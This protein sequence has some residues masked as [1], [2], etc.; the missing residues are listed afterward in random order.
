MQLRQL[1]YL[2]R[3]IDSGSLSQASRTLHIA[4]PALSRQISRLEDELGV[5]LLVRSVRGVTPT[6]A[7][8]AVYR[9]ATVIL[10]Q[11]Q[12]MRRTAEANDASLRRSS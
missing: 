7:G 6:D 1:L 3:I 11:M 12:A 8:I 9:K 2:T 10:D 5:K 4:Q